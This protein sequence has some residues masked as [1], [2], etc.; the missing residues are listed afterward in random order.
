M[1][2]EQKRARRE[3]Q[4]KQQQPPSA[5]SRA[6]RIAAVVAGLVV[7]ILAVRAVW[8]NMLP[9][10]PPRLTPAH[11]QAIASAL[12]KKGFDAPSVL[13]L[14]EQRLLTATFILDDPKNPAYLKGF[15]LDRMSAITEALHSHSPAKSYRVNING[16]TSD[17]EMQIKW[18]HAT[19]TEGDS[20]HWEPGK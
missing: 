2:V 14:D 16:T 18:G 6:I 1:S 11:N 10:E 20:V 12:A 9:P 5:R 19:Y 8:N 3:R 13:T 17:P 7:L 15:A 4:R